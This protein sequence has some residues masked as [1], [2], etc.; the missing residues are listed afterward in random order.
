MGGDLGGLGKRSSPKFEVGDGC[1]GRLNILRNT[2][3]MLAKAQ[4]ELE[5]VSSRN[6]FMK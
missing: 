3:R 5:K 4:T 2:C 6:F 1:M